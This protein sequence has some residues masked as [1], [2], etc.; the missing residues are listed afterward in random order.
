MTLAGNDLN[1]IIRLIQ[2]AS[3]ISLA[4]I[5]FFILLFFLFLL[6]AT[7]LFVRFDLL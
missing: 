5:Y 6:P 1:P 2:M 3:F 4:T 7:S